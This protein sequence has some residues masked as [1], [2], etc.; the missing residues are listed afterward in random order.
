M[1]TLLVSHPACLQHLTPP[2]HPERPDRLRAVESAL[3]ADRF[4]PLV[5]EEA[6]TAEFDTITLVHPLDYVTAIRDATPQQGMV[7]LDADTSMSPGSFEA[8]LRAIGGALAPVR[9]GDGG[10]GAHPLRFGLPRRP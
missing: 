1:A 8:A 10:H 2:G 5:R 9:A 7:R 4:K 3:A 6:P